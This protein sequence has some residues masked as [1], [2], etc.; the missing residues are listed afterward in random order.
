LKKLCFRKKEKAKMIANSLI[1]EY[2]LPFTEKY[3]VDVYQEKDKV[4]LIVENIQRFVG[5]ELN[6]DHV[7]GM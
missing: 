2:N 7:S 3:D 4:L 6:F 1:E 5:E